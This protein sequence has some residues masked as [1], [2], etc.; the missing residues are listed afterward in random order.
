MRAI[1]V[2]AFAVLALVLAIVVF[3]WLGPREVRPVWYAC[4][5]FLSPTLPG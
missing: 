1:R 2:A 4:M 3:Q 5:L